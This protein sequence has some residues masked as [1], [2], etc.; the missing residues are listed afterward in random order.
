MGGLSG[1]SLEDCKAQTCAVGGNT[2]NYKPDGT[3]D[4]K[5]CEGD[6]LQL[7]TCCGGHDIYTMDPP[8]KICLLIIS[9]LSVKTK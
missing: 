6:D 2:L 1:A 7:S 9:Q 3:C 8:G 4:I 5:K